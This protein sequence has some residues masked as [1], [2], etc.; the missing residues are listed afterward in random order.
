MKRLYLPLL[1]VLLGM[2]A[3][4]R[5]LTF[6]IGDTPITDGQTIN[7]TDIE[8]TDRGDTYNVT[9]APE[10]YIASDIFTSKL[11]VTA[12][13]TSGQQIQMCAGGT[14]QA[15]TTVTKS[16]IAIQPNTKLALE[17]DYN[18]R[19]LSGDVPVVV[20]TIEAQDG[21]YTATHKSFTIVMGSQASVTV[22]EN[23]NELHAVAGAIEYAL[24]APAVF[25][26]YN[27]DGLLVTSQQLN[28]HG[29][30]STAGLPTG[31]YVYTLGDRSGKLYIR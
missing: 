19:N 10:L 31:V 6:Y 27:I 11:S 17:F 2:S 28:G 23:H 5:E 13:C 25:A 26:L 18:A 21:T 3:Q 15:G 24:D 29:S 30:I 7:F 12:T 14:C 20:T 16:D 4:A 8:V 9:M 1:A 22:I